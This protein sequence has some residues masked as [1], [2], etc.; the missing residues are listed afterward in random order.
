MQEMYDVSS[1]D[2]M[3]QNMP[4]AR[5]NPVDINICVDADHTGN[6]ITRKSH[7]GII[8][9]L[10]IAPIVWYSKKQNT[11]ESSTFT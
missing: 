11:I 4:E 1:G 9:F 2:E 6:K 10:N 7:T 5:G 8:I 3:S